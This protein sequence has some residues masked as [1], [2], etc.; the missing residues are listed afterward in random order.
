MTPVTKQH[1]I[2]K[3][4]KCGY[5]E[6]A[7]SGVALLGGLLMHCGVKSVLSYV[8]P[9]LAAYIRNQGRSGLLKGVDVPKDISPKVITRLRMPKVSK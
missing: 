2:V 6:N 5:E 8:T 9:D 3:C 1:S 4:P 7:L